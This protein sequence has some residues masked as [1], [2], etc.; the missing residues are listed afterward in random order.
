MRKGG[1]A[2]ATGK[3]ADR[4]YPEKY[5]PEIDISDE[6]DNVLANRYQQYIGIL[7]WAIELERIDIHVEVAKLSLFTMNPRI[8]H[9]EAVYSIFAYIKKHLR[10]KLVFDPS[11]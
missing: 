7:R 6:L 2:L 8:G 11:C 3:S 10:S 1:F 5:R 4:P 9:L